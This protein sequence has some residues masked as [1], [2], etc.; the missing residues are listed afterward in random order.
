VRAYAARSGQTEAQYLKRMGP[1]VTPETAGD[2][3]LE[4][5]SKERF[6][7]APAYLLTGAGLKPLG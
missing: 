4:L 5:P 1:P 6:D 7:P 3:V 2:A